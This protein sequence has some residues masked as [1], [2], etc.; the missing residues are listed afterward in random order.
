MGTTRSQRDHALERLYAAIPEIPDCDGRCYISCG[1]IEMSDR[2]R[3]R[4]RERGVKITPHDEAYNSIDVFYCDALT[5]E[6]RCS[7]YEVRPIVCRLWGVVEDMKCPFGCIPRGGWLSR[8]DGVRLVAASMRV[9]GGQTMRSVAE[10]EQALSTEA[11]MH[12]MAIDRK[13]ADKG[14]RMRML[15]DA[16]RND[17]D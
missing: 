4:I 1:P 16:Y 17:D 6:H 8:E 13:V 12:R 5:A 11:F 9:G 7:V 10:I 2:E 3:Q 15:P 14:L